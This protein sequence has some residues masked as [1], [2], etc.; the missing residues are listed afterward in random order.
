MKFFRERYV[1]G[2]FHFRKDVKVFLQKK[3]KTDIRKRE[4]TMLKNLLHVL[5][6]KVPCPICL[7]LPTNKLKCFKRSCGN[8]L[9][10][11]RP[12]QPRPVFPPSAVFYPFPRWDGG[13]AKLLLV[14]ALEHP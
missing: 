11:L 10:H 2:K 5:Y 9:S 13:N 3:H 8:D 6:Q 12:G 4:A 7:T 1:G 14:A